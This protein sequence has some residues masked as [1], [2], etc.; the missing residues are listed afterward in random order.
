M[1][2]HIAGTAC[3][4]RAAH[5]RGFADDREASRPQPSPDH[6]PIYSSRQRSLQMRAKPNLKQN[7]GNREMKAD[8]IQSRDAIDIPAPLSDL[9]SLFYLNIKDLCPPVSREERNTNEFASTTVQPLDRPTS[10]LPSSPNA[11]LP[12]GLRLSSP[13]LSQGHPSAKL[14]SSQCRN[15]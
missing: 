12:S 6:R 11:P 15:T 9:R 4:Q 1:Q 7:C 2:L 5:R 3:K 8:L 13:Y 14:W 10:V